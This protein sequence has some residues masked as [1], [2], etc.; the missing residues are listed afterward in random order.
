[1][2]LLTVHGTVHLSAAYT[3]SSITP[4]PAQGEVVQ[5][6]VVADARPAWPAWLDV[7]YAALGSACWVRQPH[8]RPTFH[9]VWQRLDALVATTNSETRA[10]ILEALGGTGPLAPPQS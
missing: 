6:V 10:L 4:P 1:M 2:P 8:L 5:Q 3:V 9:E 7:E